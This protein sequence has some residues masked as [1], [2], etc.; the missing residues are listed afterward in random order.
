MR[1][2]TSRPAGRCVR[3]SGPGSVRE[4][5]DTDTM[6]TLTT[7]P[8][9]ASIDVA[10]RPRTRVILLMSAA[11]L[12]ALGFAV[13]QYSL[14]RYDLVLN[15]PEWLWIQL[16]SGWAFLLAGL[17]AK[18]ARP[19]SGIGT[20]MVLFGL[21]W[22]GRLVFI[23]PLIQ[24]HDIGEA[25]A[26][27]GVLFVI[28]LSFPSGRLEGWER[29]AAGAWL[30]FIGVLAVASVMLTDFYAG[31]DDSIC[32]PS[33]LL[34]VEHDPALYSDVLRIGVII[35]LPILLGLLWVLINRWRQATRVG[36]RSLTLGTFAFPVMTILVSIPI[37]S[38]TWSL[39]FLSTRINMYIEAVAL[40][41]LPAVILASL[42]QT[43]LSQARVADMMRSLEPAPAPE[44]LESHLRRALLSPE[45][46]LV[47]R[48]EGS[49]AYVGVDGKPLVDATL[50]GR[51]V[52]V[53]DE[54]AAIVHDPELDND[55]VLSAGKA[56]WLAINNVRL[57][58]EL[59]AQL[60][61]VQESR[62][63]LVRATDDAR[64]KVE[65]DLHDGAQQ[66]L[67]ALSASLRKA[68]DRDSSD[69]SAVDDLLAV[70]AEEADVAIGEL[71]DLARGVHPAILTQAGIGPAVSSLVD[72]APIPVSMEI[73]SERFSPETEATA[74]FVITEGLSNSF[75]HSAAD[76]VFVE[77]SRQGEE[78]RVVIE[79]DGAGGTQSDGSGI[80]GLVDR[81]GAV[82]GRLRAGPGEKGGSKL[83]AWIPLSGDG[84]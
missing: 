54:H 37:V 65:R 76:H 20:L 82:G 73:V 18:R 67:V 71:R 39:W 29:W 75:K 10:M 3:Y 84:G 46:R 21:I 1:G 64:R 43:R 62:R 13:Q 60:L 40:L 68:L 31:V 44:A 30:T 4:N 80:R 38:Q 78:L 16:A 66:R 45:A 83:T 6:L 55:L 56:A 61:E 59:R 15:V 19:Q 72:R 26:L 35:G 63:R 14:D 79:D 81:V 7:R 57:Q 9:C 48:R 41:I 53:L 52:T 22:I 23:A 28:L 69:T 11:L 17:T 47:F 24:W 42:L 12:S 51:S 25:I 70:A 36:R 5:P 74:Y 34:L 77:V 27:Y 32:C 50:E 33:H 2:H 49:G 8:S 58:A